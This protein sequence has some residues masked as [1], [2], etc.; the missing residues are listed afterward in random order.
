VI[1]KRPL[2]TG[3][4][5]FLTSCLAVAS[6]ACRGGGATSTPGSPATSAGV[7]LGNDIQPVF[8]GNCVVCHQG[9]GQ[10][11][12]TLEPGK[13]YGNLVNIAST[14]SPL[15]RVAPG[16]PDKSYLLNK[17]QG[18]QGQIGGSGAQMP[19][20]AA[21]LPSAQIGLIQQW[22]QEGALNN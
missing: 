16:A 6:L 12:L 5:V 15:K 19:Y 22:I 1:R 13:S 17:L 10:A 11:G 7:R 21:P 3:A 2:L 14:E 20:G 4:L 8:T 9:A 18:T